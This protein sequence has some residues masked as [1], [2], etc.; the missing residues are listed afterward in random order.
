MAIEEISTA[1]LLRGEVGVEQL[2]LDL[3][4]QFLERQSRRL[5][6]RLAVDDRENTLEAFPDAS[7][8]RAFGKISQE[9]DKKPTKRLASASDRSPHSRQPTVKQPLHDGVVGR[10]ELVRFAEDCL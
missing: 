7:P 3:R 2:V 6:R 5:G 9:L 1:H 8:G 4:Q 10:V